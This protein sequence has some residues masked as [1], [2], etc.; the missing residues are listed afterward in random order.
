VAAP[1]PQRGWLRSQLAHLHL[2]K[3]SGLAYT[4]RLDRGERDYVVSVRGPA[5]GHKRL[6]LSLELRF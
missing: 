6:G 5:L 4:R 3:K 2:H 1:P